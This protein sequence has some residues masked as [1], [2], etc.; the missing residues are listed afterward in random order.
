MLLAPWNSNAN[1]ARALARFLNFLHTARGGK[2][3]LQASEADHLAFHQWR[4]RNEAGPRVEGGTWNQ[5]VSLVNQFYEWAVRQGHVAVVPIPHRDRRPPPMGTVMRGSQPGTVPATYAHDENGERIEW[6]PPAT[7][8]LWRDVG[9]RG[10]TSEGLPTPWSRFRG[11]WAARNATFTDVMVR[12]FAMA[13]VLRLSPGV[14][15]AHRSFLPRRA[16]HG[17]GHPESPG[18]APQTAPRKGGLTVSGAPERP[19]RHCAISGEHIRHTPP[20]ITE[21]SNQATISH[22]GRCTGHDVPHSV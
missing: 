2:G 4:R 13:H 16:D 6:M 9:I 8:R 3:W 19:A 12:T 18:T 21:R 17:R 11:R 7:Y 1:R 20:A 10:Y 5:E 14:G 22:H 15:I